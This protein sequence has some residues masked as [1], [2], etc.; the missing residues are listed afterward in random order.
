MT[1]ESTRV[2]TPFR[3]A[4]EYD[5]M[6]LATYRARGARAACISIASVGGAALLRYDD[7]GYFN[8]VYGH[9]EDLVD[10]LDEVEAFFRGSP[11]GCRMITP[12]LSLTSLFAR[13]SAARGW[14][15]D[16]EFVWLT[17]DPLPAHSIV[18]P[19]FEVRAPRADEHALF[20][21]TY[22]HAFDA[23]PSRIPAAVDNM[24]HLF[25]NPH[26]HF[27]L[28]CLDG[29]PAGVAMLY[30]AGR[31]ALLCG[32][33]MLPSYRGAR[34][35]ELLLAARIQLARSLGCTDIH[36]WATH[37]GRSHTNM[38]LAG[39]RPVGMTTTLRLPADRLGARP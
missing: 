16:Q 18:Q 14:V 3:L 26:L 10:R 35:H 27:L 4:A 6:R 24:R 38:E 32:G 31:S 34:G 22:L 13:A 1:L 20:F 28:A 30:Q 19:R 36:S 9:E 21:H 7:V 12:A 33:A 5:G 23:D 8:A 25:S 2:I 11:H 37:G 39:L 15:P 17:A 29:Q